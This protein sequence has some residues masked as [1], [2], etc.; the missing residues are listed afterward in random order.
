MSEW[1]R[2]QASGGPA[3]LDL[4]A[5]GDPPAMASDNNHRIVFWNRGAERLLGRSAPEALGRHCYD[6]LGGRDVF[7]NRFC[8]ADCAVMAMTRRHEAVHGFEIQVAPT[9][10]AHTALNVTIVQIPGS[11]PDLFT[12]VHI[13]QQVDEAGRLAR[14]LAAAGATGLQPPPVNLPP[15]LRPAAAAGPPL[16]EREKEILGWI[17]AGLQ[18]KEIAAKLDISLAT[19]RNHI[20]NILEKLAVHS[21]LEALSLAFRNGWIARR[22]ASA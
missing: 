2:H 1:F 16:T 17:A 18:N 19:V 9:G 11:R 6:V 15:A 14:A 10:G 22:D 5:S 12:V 7:G 21:K 13:F 8:R 4:L 3:L 20:H